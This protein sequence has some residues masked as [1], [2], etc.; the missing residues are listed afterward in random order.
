MKKAFLDT[1]VLLVDQLISP[2]APKGQLL[3][4]IKARFSVK[5]E[6]ELWPLPRT[7]R[8]PAIL[9]RMLR[10]GAHEDFVTFLHSR[11]LSSI[12]STSRWLEAAPCVGE[13]ALEDVYSFCRSYQP[14]DWIRRAI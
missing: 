8:L 4:R 11:S 9:S 5:Y 10:M 14:F 3:S 13:H 1:D 2:K 7:L 6:G 12:S